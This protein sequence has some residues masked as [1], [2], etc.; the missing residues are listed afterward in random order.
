MASIKDI[1]A[2]CGVSVATVSKALNGQPDISDST[3]ARVLEKVKAMGYTP[4]SSARALK[5]SRSHN[6]GVLLADEAGNGLTQEF[7]AALLEAFRKQAESSGYDITFIHRRSGTQRRSYLEHCRYR[8]VD[9]VI[10]ACVGVDF[11][12][13]GVVELVTSDLPVITV[14]HIFNDRSAVLSDNVD[15]PQQLVDYLCS[16]GHR[17]IAFIHGEAGASVTQKRL[18]S[19]YRACEAHGIE[20]PD[21]YVRGSAYRDPARCAE[22]TRALLALSERPTAILFPDDLSAI[23]GMEAIRKEGLLI[24]RDISVA[25]YD[26]IL[27]TR[28]ITPQLTTWCQNTDELGRIAASRLIQQIEHP[29]VTLPEQ[30]MIPGRLQPGESCAPPLKP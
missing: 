6:L 14:D 1:A 29:R 8:C 26:G 19:Y 27:L 9:G 20:P 16:M 17:R 24:P 13:P 3:R 22:E 5:T 18:A 30:Q 4:N 2:A 23:G 11:N 28:V 10:V 21:A 25:G 12:D 15:G 7:F